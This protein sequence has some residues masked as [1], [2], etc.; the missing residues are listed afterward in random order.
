MFN[1]NQARHPPPHQMYAPP[2]PR[3]NY[4][5]T[6]GSG[7]QFYTKP[8]TN[9]PS[10]QTIEFD[11]GPKITVF[12]GNISDKIPDAMIKKLIAA[13]GPVANWKRVSTF[14][15]CEYDGPKSG[16]RAVRLLHGY[17]VD[18]KKLVAKVDAKN[19]ALLDTAKDEENKKSD[20][21]NT[22]NSDAANEK[23]NDE[24]ALERLHQIVEEYKDELKTANSAENQQPHPRSKQTVPSIE[25]EEGKRDLINKEIGRFRKIAE[26]EEAKKE[27]DKKK[28]ENLEKERSER[29]EKRHTPSPERKSSSRR[30][31][32]SRDRDREAQR[33][34][35]REQR[36]RERERERERREIDRRREQELREKEMRE[37]ERFRE[38]PKQ[39]KNAKEIQREKEIAEEEYERRR[40]Q[41]KAREKHEDYL[42]R[43]EAWES[44]ERKKAKEYEKL[45]E[46]EIKREEK[47]ERE[48]KIMK[49]FLEDYDDER[50]DPKFY[51]GKA[52]KTLMAERLAEAD[53]DL[54]DREEEREELEKLKEEIFSG[55]YD[56]PTQ[57]FERQKQE[58]EERY[59]P[60]ILIDVNMDEDDQQE[61]HRDKT[62]EQDRAKAR[63]RRITQKDRYVKDKSSREFSSLD[64]EPIE[65]DSSG[66][67]NFSPSNN[68][69]GSESRDGMDDEMSR[70]SLLSNSNTPTTPNSPSGNQNSAT[71]IGMGFSLSLNKKRKIDPKS[72]FALDDDGEEVNGPQK[73]KLVP[74]DYEDGSSN[75]KKTKRDGEAQKK[76][77]ADIARSQEEKRK[78]HKQIINK[79]PID[80][81]DLF[82]HPLDR[83]EIDGTIKKKV[84]SWINKKI[85]EYIGEPEPTLV[86]FIC[87]KL[88]AGS[89]PQSILD[90]VKMILD[91]E[92][93]I[94]V[95][96]MWR[97][98]IFEVEAKKL[99]IK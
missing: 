54:K 79:I 5:K 50:D 30:R 97:L 49:E 62:R 89:T 16:A 37:R 11:E 26:E 83:T 81:E 8:P 31:S 12:V 57:E 58:M 17:E 75:A 3:E 41:K 93:D 15:F 27:K 29:N 43:L 24:I 45:R 28:R 36:E 61:Y 63:E 67:H 33:E 70:N 87:S 53:A 76:T 85:I 68:R 65:S 21:N 69:G 35:D 46:K 4:G 23:K 56:N 73:K 7:P 10:N 14:G 98:I 1:N 52:Y 86:D 22:R 72:A 95:V 80:K 39:M 25:I 92:A 47:R 90:D 19:Q 96:K 99:G 94:F 60:K 84:Q 55:K 44:R 34:R 59:K 88:L 6:I 91:E 64:A 18:G 74:L 71:G 82:N 51:K 77:E 38:E 9:I 78:L 2:P 42:A 32:R 48:A 40:A 13:C 20:A 66:G